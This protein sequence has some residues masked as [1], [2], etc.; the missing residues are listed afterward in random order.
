[1]VYG[2][3]GMQLLPGI[4]EIKESTQIHFERI[5]SIYLIQQLN[6]K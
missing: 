1:L 4:T 3:W 2:K 5:I 6:G